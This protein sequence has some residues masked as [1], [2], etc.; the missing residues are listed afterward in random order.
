[1]TEGSFMTR[2]TQ[3]QK[4]TK[5][6]VDAAMPQPNRYIIWDS[7]LPGFGVRIEPSGRK[8]FIARYRAGG[9]R[10]GILRQATIGR[11]GTVTP[12]EARVT[13][14][15]ILGSAAVGGDPLE[16]KRSVRQ[17]GITVAEICDWYLEE[18]ETGRLLGRRGRPIKK[19]T[20][21]TDRNRI[22]AHVKPLLGKRAIQHLEVRDFEQMQADIAAGKTARF[23]K[24][25]QSRPR[26]G[27]P[28]GGSGTAGRTLGML[29]TIIEHANRRGMVTDNPARG[30]RKFADQ[31]RTKRLSLDQIATLGAAMNDAS[32]EDENPT[33][34]A[35]IRLLLL[36][37]LRRGEALSIRCGWVMP[38]GGIDFPDTKSGAQVRPIGRAAMDV[39]RTQAA[40]A[41][42]N[43]VDWLFPADRGDGHFVGLPKVLHR[44]CKRAKLEGITA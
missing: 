3:A 37:G 32:G 29:R 21:S 28:L 17:K 22:E 19:S 41:T 33:G 4:L 10:T 43:Q 42:S 16:E 2:A 40:L 31:R 11:F 38:A 7:D 39:L 25:G 8:T 1:M 20:L 36:T 14:R 6:G 5:S 26:G 15:K 9:G 44:I 24:E 23:F 35:A 30:A 13:A 18:A 27:I 12:A 34:L